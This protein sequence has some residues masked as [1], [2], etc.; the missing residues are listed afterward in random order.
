MEGN[1]QKH[2]VRLGSLGTQPDF[3]VQFKLH[4]KITLN[5]YNK[6]TISDNHIHLR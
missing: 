5:E 4:E 2:L 6:I 3:Q 1:E